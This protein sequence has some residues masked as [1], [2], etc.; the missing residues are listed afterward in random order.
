LENY[1]CCDDYYY[2]KLKSH[3]NRIYRI[4][5]YHNLTQKVLNQQTKYHSV[6]EIGLEGQK[7]LNESQNEKLSPVNNNFD[8]ESS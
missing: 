8:K 1:P 7:D 5:N 3:R 6:N 4:N 2:R